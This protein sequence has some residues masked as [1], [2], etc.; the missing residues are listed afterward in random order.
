MQIDWINGG[1]IAAVA[2]TIGALLKF[3]VDLWRARS[4]GAVAS[5]QTTLDQFRLLTEQYDKLA[6]S[7]ADQRANDQQYFEARI[8]ECEARCAKCEEDHAKS[9][10]LLRDERKSR[11]ADVTR[12]TKRIGELE[13]EVDDLLD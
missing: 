3:F 10:Q 1:I 4:E 6:V 7:I 13:K 11:Q 2:A 12:L 9:R 5:D 8:Q